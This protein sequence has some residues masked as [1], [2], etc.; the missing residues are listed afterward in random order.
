MKF[1]N[2]SANDVEL[3][4]KYGWYDRKEVISK[5]KVEKLD[6]FTDIISESYA[7]YAGCSVYDGDHKASMAPL[8]LAVYGI[9][10][11]GKTTINLSY[12]N[13]QLKV[14]IDGEDE[15]DLPS[16]SKE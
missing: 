15:P 12:D 4:C 14:N 2:Y 10:F 16:P 3:E 8:Y 6:S 1:H 9:S 7:K 11:F 5:V 13:K